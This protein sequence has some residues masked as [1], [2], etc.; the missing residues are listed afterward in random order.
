MALGHRSNISG[1]IMDKAALLP[2][3]Q[4]LDDVNQSIRGLHMRLCEAQRFGTVGLWSYNLDKDLFSWSEESYRI[5]GRTPA[6]FVLTAVSFYALIHPSDREILRKSLADAIR[7]QKTFQTEFRALRP[8]GTLRWVRTRAEMPAGPERSA[9]VLG[10]FHDVTEWRQLQEQFRQAQKLEVL[11][12]LAGGVAHDFNNLL[13]IMRGR[14]E[15]VLLDDLLPPSA[16]ESLNLVL[17]AADQAT[18]LARQLVTFSRRQPVRIQPLDL[19]KVIAELTKLLG[20]ILGADIHV[21]TALAATL[22]FVQ[23]DTGLVEQVILN[24]AVRARECLRSGGELIFKTQ[25]VKIDQVKVHHPSKSGAG[26]FVELTA[27]V[28]QRSQEIQLEPVSTPTQASG[29]QL[30]LAAIQVIM[31][32]LGGWL[33]SMDDAVPVFKVFFPASAEPKR[34]SAQA[35]GTAFPQGHSERI[36]LVEDDQGLRKF[37]FLL[38]QRL[39]YKVEEASSGLEAMQRWEQNKGAFD[40]ILT[41]VVL[42]SGVSGWDL[43]TELRRKQPLLSMIVMTGYSPEPPTEAIRSDK[44]IS[45]LAKPFTPEILAQAV[46]QRL[47]SPA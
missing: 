3:T 26:V 46:R 5:F 16:N 21:R 23:A 22:P 9:I 10:T 8:D 19:N 31:E 32:P 40:L 2:Q 43:V 14:A 30:G 47:G 15:M 39:G 38:L 24:L 27:Q 18:H 7:E 28:V 6:D 11:G 35:E 12:L 25:V 45:V 36:L 34:S 29:I 37:L 17:K 33:E 44:A 41:D 1:S 42:P 4:T 20:H 13:T